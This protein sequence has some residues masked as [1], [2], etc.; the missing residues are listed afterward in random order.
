MGYRLSL[1]ILL[2]ASVACSSAPA[3]ARSGA[4]AAVSMASPAPLPSVAVATLK[5]ETT[6]VAHFAEGR[7]ALVSMWATWCEACSQEMDSLN[8]LHA[9]TLVDGDAMVI[10]L[11][12]GEER[13][14]V[15]TFARR[16]GLQYPLLVDQGFAFA[17]A[18]G[19]RRIP[20]TLVL[21][22]RGRVVFRGE[23]LDAAALEAMR[24]A[25]ADRSPSL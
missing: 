9:K 13:D 15:A 1:L 24:K 6:E 19:Q 7:V 18:L 16:R 2:A 21:D 11:A 10:G 23:A 17:D 8:R 4:L 3:P 25:I 14:K 22:R 5:G 12:I 20:E